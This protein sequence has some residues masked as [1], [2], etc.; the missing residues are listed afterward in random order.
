[1]ELSNRGLGV[2]ETIMAIAIIALLSWVVFEG[3]KSPRAKSR[4][5][6][7]VNNIKYIQ[8]V[9]QNYFN[10]NRNYPASLDPDSLVPTYTRKIPKDPST[11]KDYLYAVISLSKTR[12]CL[13]YHLGAKLEITELESDV[14]KNDADLAPQANIC[15]G[16]AA[17]FD[18]A[19]PVYDVG[20]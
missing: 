18:G 15:P 14:F 6:E 8:S 16:S 20:Q 3:T 7:R 12:R 9:L 5:T 11:G 13:N 17:D 10:E 2:L 19:D 4:D 1:M